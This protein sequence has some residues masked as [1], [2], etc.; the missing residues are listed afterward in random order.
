MP[1]FGL[2]IE[3][4]V[5]FRGFQQPF[6]NVYYYRQNDIAVDAIV[7][8]EDLLTFIVDREKAIHSTDVNFLRG[9][10]WNTNSGS[11]QTNL[12]RVDKALTGT[13]VC[14]PNTSLDR[15]RAILVRWSAGLDSRNKPVYLRK[16]YHVCGNP[17]SGGAV[18]SAA[19]LQNTAELTNGQKGAYSTEL[20]SVRTPNGGGFPFALIAKSGRASSGSAGIHRY[21]EHHQLGDQWR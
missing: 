10:V 4:S 16:Y 5:S 13:G 7:T 9:R 15:E 8:L 12:M 21:L 19:Q 14:S 20:V 11:Q 2:S 18:F 1:D 17:P 3:K 6:A